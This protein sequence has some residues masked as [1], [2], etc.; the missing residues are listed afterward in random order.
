MSR[1]ASD[2]QRSSSSGTSTINLYFLGLGA[3]R[4]SSQSHIV[5]GHW[6][7]NLM[8]AKH[9]ALPLERHAHRSWIEPGIDRVQRR[10][11]HEG[12]GHIK[13]F[14]GWGAAVNSLPVVSEIIN[15]FYNGAVLQQIQTHG[16]VTSL[17]SQCKLPRVLRHEIEGL[18]RPDV[19]IMVLVCKPRKLQ[20]LAQS[21]YVFRT[22]PEGVHGIFAQ[23]AASCLTVT[24]GS[25]T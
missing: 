6:I 12:L 4:I 15:S 21:A 5:S 18:L 10:L 3:Q 9:L 11:E 25:A 22:I 23:A 1:P 17:L 7:L 8:A 14:K 16:E 19:A 20:H 2:C 24:S 13:G